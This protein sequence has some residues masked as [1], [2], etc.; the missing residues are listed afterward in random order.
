[1]KMDKTRIGVS[2]CCAAALLG[3]ASYAISPAFAADT[4][5]GG[6]SSG[7]VL[8]AASYADANKEDTNESGR[9]ARVKIMSGVPYVSTEDEPTET[10]EIPSDGKVGEQYING[11]MIIEIV[12]KEEV[13][14]AVADDLTIGTDLPPTGPS[15]ITDPDDGIMPMISL[16]DDTASSRNGG[17]T[18]YEFSAT[19]SNGNY[20]R[21]WHQNNAGEKV[22][23]YLYRTDK[24]TTSYVSMMEV[25]ANDQ[26]SK[27][28]YSSTAGSGTYKIVV[29][30]Y[31][32]GGKV[33][34]DVAAAQYKTNPN[35]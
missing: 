21:F 27:V 19:A 1:M 35:Y 4:S 33:S 6:T 20:I 7:T 10:F 9:M 28:H 13:Q 15:E 2:M 22:K 14:A 25:E 29:E 17:W 26:N 32:S 11:D 3:T 30:P 23:V 12:S 18:S 24:S 5:S 31:I 34:S 8:S 16:F